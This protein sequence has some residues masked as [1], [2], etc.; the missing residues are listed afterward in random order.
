DRQARLPRHD[1]FDDAPRDVDAL[2]RFK[3]GVEWLLAAWEVV[4][5]GLPAPGTPA[6]GAASYAARVEARALR[7]LGVPT[8]SARP[9]QPVREA[10][11]AEVRRLT[12]RLAEL[13]ADPRTRIA[14][15]LALFDAGP[16]S[17]LLAR[18]EAAAGREL[19]RAVD[20]FLKLRKHPELIDPADPAESSDLAAP[21]AEAAGPAGRP[22]PAGAASPPRGPSLR[23]KP[24]GRNEASRPARPNP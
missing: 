11:E 22:T 4:L 6:P 18:Y 24:A 9:A 15:D 13:S 16:E 1:E 2:N 14:E 23:P 17:Q 21:A 7:L 12:Q 8:G 20:T 10:G 19:H 5:P 3:E